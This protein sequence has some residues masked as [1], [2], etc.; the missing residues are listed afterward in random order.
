MA[1]APSFSLL[2]LRT[3]PLLALLLAACGDD[4]GTG[5]QGAG[6]NPPTP[7]ADAT[8]CPK[9]PCDDPICTDGVCGTEPKPDGT[10]IEIQASGD[11]RREVCDGTGNTRFEVDEDD[12]PNEDVDD[13]E[14]GVCDGETPTIQNAAAGTECDEDG[15]TVCNA[16]GD[17][18]EC[19]MNSQCESMVCNVQE[20]SCA[21]ATC[22]NGMLDGDETDMDCGGSCPNCADGLNCNNE[23]DCQS[24]VCS[25]GVCQAATCTDDVENGQETDRDCGGP[26]CPACPLGDDCL[27]GS[28]CVSTICKQGECD[29]INGCDPTSSMDLTA[30]NAVTITFGG[31]AGNA[32]SP[33]CIRVASGTQLT[34]EG[35]FALHP[36]VG[37]EVINNQKMQS[38][39]GPFVP[40][41]NTGMSKTVTMSN[42]GNFGFYCDFHAIGGMTGYVFV[43]P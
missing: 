13:C 18:V 27:V 25:G 5:A 6:G 26:D 42:G 11:C 29:Q 8:E 23:D 28:D 17:C 22:G 33:R 3:A 21:P 24:F 40:I 1:L 34:F 7:C 43:E 16:S 10:D 30:E 14:L 35:D 38:A 12:V 2:A 39:S 37:G 19:T 31:A 32:Y 20:G 4:S 41:T 36:L 15:G 9:G